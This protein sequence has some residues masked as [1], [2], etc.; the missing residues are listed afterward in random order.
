MY[1]ARGC[2]YIKLTDGRGRAFGEGEAR[3]APLVPSGWRVPRA[4]HVKDCLYSTM[5]G[6][7][8][9]GAEGRN[10]FFLGACVGAGSA[11]E[12]GVKARIVL[13]SA[14]RVVKCV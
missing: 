4:L 11:T 9:L 5:T 2:K 12:G 14:R 13:A 8:P 10:G 3:K 6:E 7:N 1:E